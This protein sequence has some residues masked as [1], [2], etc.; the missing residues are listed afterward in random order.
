M[1]AE[2]TITNPS[3]SGTS[4]LAE[5]NLSGITVNFRILGVSTL[6]ATSTRGFDTAD[7]WWDADDLV[8]L[9]RDGLPFFQGRVQESPRSASDAAESRSLDLVDAWQDLEDVIYQETWGIGSGS[10]LYPRCILGLNSAGANIKTGEQI[11]EVID[12]AIT[13][14]AA[15]QKGAID[16]GVQLWPSESRN[17]SCDTIIRGQLRFHPDWAA[18]LDHSTSPPTFHA[19]AKSALNAVAFDIEDETLSDFNFAEVV[20]NVPLGVRIIYESASTIDGEVYRN[21]YIDTAGVTTGRRV[22]QATLDLEGIQMQTQKSRI[23]TRTLPTNAAT[24]T[25]YFKAKWP[26]LADMPDAA[27]SWANVSFSLVPEGTQPSPINPNATRLSK[28]TAA[29][30]P[31]EL[32]RGSVEDW[33]RVKVGKVLVTYDLEIIGSPNAAQRKIL[34]HFA[35]EKKTFSVTATNATTKIYK[36]ITSFSAGEGRPIGLAA[37]IFAAATEQQHEGSITL[38]LDEVSGTRYHGNK[39]SVVNGE[40][41]VMPASII[42]G[43]SHNLDNGSTTLEFGPLPYLSAGDFLELQRLLHRRP[44]TWMSPEERTANTIGAEGK[45]SSKGDTVTGYDHSETLVPPGGGGGEPPV[46]P[47]ALSVSQ[48]G[49]IYNWRVSSVYS[50]ITDGTNGDN[51]SVENFDADFAFTGEKWV[52]VE[53]AVTDLS[54]GTLEV[55]AVDD[56]EEVALDESTPPAQNKVR[57]LIGKVNVVES[58]PVRE[59]Y[60]F[61]AARLTYGFLNGKIIRVFESCHV[62]PDYTPPDPEP[63][64]E[65]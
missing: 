52:V 9:Y 19:R 11:E 13:Q 14:G 54:V 57:L 48:D 64:P 60:R 30:L 44:V 8:T 39:I 40:N 33:M 17:Q 2:W 58:V 46:L 10:V 1:S 29:D 38:T 16:D 25:A 35:G 65:P 37:S 50:T 15:L 28:T 32:V 59:Q 7:T 41:T 45:P 49:E 56:P 21:A 6:Q 47:F 3:G 36:G 42:Y 51:L 20:R 18:W 26:E 55:L 12:Y 27:F 63:E 5:L 4:T 31:R 34:D 43:A 61:D 24:M 62:H 53:A 22:M 23:E